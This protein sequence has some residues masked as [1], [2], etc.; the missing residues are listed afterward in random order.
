ME[1]KVSSTNQSGGVTAGQI[2]GPA[3]SVTEGPAAES[4][5]PEPARPSFWKTALAGAMGKVIFAVA[6][7]VVLGLAAYLGFKP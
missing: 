5:T 4:E 1:I 7:A 6:A 2:V 3:G